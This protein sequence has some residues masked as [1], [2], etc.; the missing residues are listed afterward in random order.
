MISAQLK[1]RFW[2]GRA[3]IHQP[4]AAFDQ[5]DFRR[6]GAGVARVAIAKPPHQAPDHAAD[7]GGEK[8][9][10]PAMRHLQLEQQGLQK[11]QADELRGGV[12]ADGAGA[13]AVGKPAGHHLIVD[14]IGGRL[15][16][17]DQKAQR[18]QA[19]EG[20]DDAQKG[21]RHRPQDQDGGIE[22]AWPDAVNQPAA[23]NLEQGIGPTE[24]RQDPAHMFRI[25]AQLFAHHRRGERD[26]A[27]IQEGDGDTDENHHHHHI[28]MTGGFFGKRSLLY[29]MSSHHS[30]KEPS[31]CRQTGGRQR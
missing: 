26:V 1:G 11:S 13:F 21:G 30:A 19:D 15:Q 22:V 24:A 14:G 23:G 12:K 31:S 10:A 3:Q 9:R 27:A 17:P 5:F 28:A 7:A 6:I 2:L 20:A 18:E 4:A 25:D 8:H 16:R 29:F